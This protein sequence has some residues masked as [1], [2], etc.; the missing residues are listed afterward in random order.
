MT[1]NV[2]I[3]FGGESNEYEVS[4]K[5]AACVLGFLEDT[6]YNLF[7]IGITKNGEWYLF[8]GQSSEISD[9]SWVEN[10]NNR[11]CRPVSGGIAAYDGKPIRLDCVFPVLHGIGCEDGRLQGLFDT[12]HIPYIG[13]GCAA[14]ALCM[15][16]ALCKAYLSEYG[17]P[18]VK[19]LVFSRGDAD[20]RRQTAEKL[21]F[22]V[23][24]K[25]ARSGSSVGISKVFC[26][27]ELDDALSLAF[28][29]DKKV[30]IE[31]D[32]CGKE[33][34][35]AVLENSDGSLLVSACGEIESGSEFYDYDAKYIKNTSEMHIPA[36]ISKEKSDEIRELA[37]KIFRITEARS[38]ARIDFFCGDKIY[39]NEINTLPGFTDISMYP[40]L[41]NDAGISQKALVRRLIAASLQNARH[42]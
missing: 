34:E 22:P 35:V 7:R 9:G 1:E 12:L 24:V 25:P 18:A 16:K 27:A 28:S 42:I 13:S 11:K 31:E 19:T 10:P 4:L 5:S 14:S 26:D 17:I 2:G 20:I 23:F 32:A 3:L 41:I 33:I 30:L 15:D 6:G 21:T 40:L 37:K 39:F 36:C 8:F 38:L 29:I